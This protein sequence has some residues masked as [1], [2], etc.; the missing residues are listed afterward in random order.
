[1]GDLLDVCVPTGNFGNILAAFFAKRM[2]V[3]LGRLICA[4]NRNNVLTAFF[5]DGKYDRNRP[6]YTTSSPSMDILIS[7]NLERLLYLYTDAQYTANCMHLLQQS[8]CYEITTALHTALLTDFYG[9]CANEEA[10]Y[11]AIREALEKT[12]H[13]IDPHTA[14]AYACAQT[15]RNNTGSTAPLLIV[16]TA[17]PYKFAQDVLSALDGK[18]HDASFQT[19][20]QLSTITNTLIPKPLAALNHQTPRFTGSIQISQMEDKVRSF[21]QA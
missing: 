15:Y 20:Q 5:E 3:P 13:L 17:S 1:M 11:A 16:S 8:G 12:G 9:V 7:S 14:V 21:V 6:F 19:M 10:C 2:G 4:S 18:K